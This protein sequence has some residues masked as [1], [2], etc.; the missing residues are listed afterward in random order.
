MSPANRSLL[1]AANFL[2]RVN[3]DLH[4]SIGT[5]C[6]ARF[7]VLREQKKHDLAF[8]RNEKKKTSQ[9]FSVLFFFSLTHSWAF[10]VHTLNCKCNHRY[11]KPIASLPSYSRWD[12]LVQRNCWRCQCAAV[13][14]YNRTWEPRTHVCHNL[15]NAFCMRSH[16]CDRLNH[17]WDVPHANTIHGTFGCFDNSFDWCVQHLDRR[18]SISFRTLNCR[19]CHRSRRSVHLLVHC[20]NRPDTI[21]V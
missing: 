21:H 3:R 12:N 16:R 15:S 9:S 1:H 18:S 14:S 5:F 11:R 17:K 6:M 2:H 13:E 8:V 19:R 4:R 7:C 20:C 10:W